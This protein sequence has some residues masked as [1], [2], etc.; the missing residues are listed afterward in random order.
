MP[1]Y[2]PTKG[3]F[4]LTER[5]KGMKAS[6]HKRIQEQQMFLISEAKKYDN[7]KTTE[8][9]QVAFEKLKYY[10]A[11]SQLIIIRCWP[12]EMLFK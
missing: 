8:A 1:E 3:Y 10:M 7:P 11:E 2:T 9:N 5:P 12:H 6:I 4:D